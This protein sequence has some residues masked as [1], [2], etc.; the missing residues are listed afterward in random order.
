M[1][2]NRFEITLLQFLKGDARLPGPALALTSALLI[3]ISLFMNEESGW[4]MALPGDI[5]GMVA[6]LAKEFL[7]SSLYDALKPLVAATAF[8][9][10]RMVA[11]A[12][13][14]YISIG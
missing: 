10:L 12:W 6:G 2:R 8:R 1:T 7:Y 5:S 9:G 3:A 14:S 4:R 11:K 13:K